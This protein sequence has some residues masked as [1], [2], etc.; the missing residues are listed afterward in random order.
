MSLL[1]TVLSNASQ[2]IAPQQMSQ[3][4]SVQNQ[5]QQA[6]Q[7]AVATGAVVVQL[8]ANR[9]A[10]HG[11]SR[12]TDASFEKQQQTAKKEDKKEQD[13]KKGA[14]VSVNVSA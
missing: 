12:Q 1:A 6:I 14:T 10:S 5:A 8:T 3:R 2:T 11:D 9:A 13:E 4:T 7:T